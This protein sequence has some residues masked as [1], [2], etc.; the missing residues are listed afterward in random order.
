MRIVDYRWDKLAEGCDMRSRLNVQWQRT[1]GEA[2]FDGYTIES[3]PLNREILV[4]EGDA[5]E[6][7]RI[8]RLVESSMPSV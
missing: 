2:S 1:Y 8:Q 4:Y 6:I 7:R 5:E 3:F